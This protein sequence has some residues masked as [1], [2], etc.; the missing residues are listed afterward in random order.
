[1]EQKR[2]AFCRFYFLTDDELL[3]ILANAANTDVIQGHLKTCF[4]GLVKLTIVESDITMMWSK[5]KEGVKLKK[6][7]KIKQ[8]E[9]VE[10]WLNDV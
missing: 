6:P 4:D 10:G 1:M 5:E 9:V 7:A 8:N 2:G 3:D